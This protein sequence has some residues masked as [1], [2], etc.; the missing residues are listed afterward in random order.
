MSS[1]PEIRETP[2]PA[3]FAALLLDARRKVVWRN[4]DADAL[5]GMVGKS[6]DRWG[7]ELCVS[8]CDACPFGAPQGGQLNYHALLDA[9][10]IGL[11]IRCSPLPGGG[12]QRAFVFVRK[13]GGDAGLKKLRMLAQP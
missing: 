5:L 6:V 1:V 2:A 11:D 4:P 3:S 7:D 12:E 8:S 9:A 10:P 13:I